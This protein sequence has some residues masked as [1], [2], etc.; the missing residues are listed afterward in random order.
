[1]QSLTENYLLKIYFQ[2]TRVNILE[3]TQLE[4]SALKQNHNYV[5]EN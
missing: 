4:D 1:M 2:M 3:K 5:S